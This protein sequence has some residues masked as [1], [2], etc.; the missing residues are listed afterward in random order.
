MWACAVLGFRPDEARNWTRY[1]FASRWG[2]EGRS[3][4]K[5]RLP[6]SVF[7]KYLAIA[8]RIWVR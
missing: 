6:E 4:T 1:A 8:H 7:A 3:P 5:A 2:V